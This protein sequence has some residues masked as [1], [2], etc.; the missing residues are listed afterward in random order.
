MKELIITLFGEY[1]PLMS[2]VGDIPQYVIG[3]AGL[4]FAWIA[5]VFLFSVVLYCLLRMIGGIF[6]S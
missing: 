3:I 2:T 5:G 1:V 4:D 6:K